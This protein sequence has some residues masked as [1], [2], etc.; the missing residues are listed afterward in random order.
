[1]TKHNN[2][3]IE[4]G[5]EELPPKHIRKLA[6][7][8][9]QGLQIE[10][11]RA[12]L[13]FSDIQSFATPRRLALI[14]K[15]LIAE[16]PEQTIKRKGPSLE[17]AFN[18]EGKPT[19]ACLGF[20]K[21]CSVSVEQLQK[22]Q[23][24]KGTWL[25]YRAK[26]AGA[27][28]HELL[29][30]L[31]KK[32]IKKLPIP[33][34]MRWS[35]LPTE[36][37]RPVHWLV[38]LYGKDVVH[39]DILGKTASNITYG[40][41]FHHPGP[42]KLKHADIYQKSLQKAFVV[43]CLTER[44][45][46]IK[47]Q[48]ESQA[49]EL[50][51]TPVIPDDLLDEVANIVEWP[52]ALLAKFD[53]AFLSI[54][55]E[56]LI[57]AMQDHQ[58]VFALEEHQ[59]KLLAQFIF[60]SNIASKKP[61][62]VIEGNEKVMRARLS[63]A[64]FFFEIDCKTPLSHRIEKLKSVVFQHKLGSVYDKTQRMSQLSK[65][66]ARHLSEDESASDKVATL[67]KADLVS[68]MVLEFP[69]LQGIM[70]YYYALNDQLPENIATAIRDHYLPRFSGDQLP[71]T[72]LSCIV[73]LADRIDTLTALFAID[74]PPTGD[75]DPF[76]LRRAAYGI[77]R[78]I[79]EKQLPLDLSELSKVALKTLEHKD[80]PTTILETLMDFYFERLRSWYLEKNISPDTLAAV[81]TQRPTCPFD[82]D[83]RVKAVTHFRTL[84]EASCLA[85]ANKRV[86]NIL[87]KEVNTLTDLT[88]NESLATEKAEQA[89]AKS[90][91]LYSKK[92]KP[93]KERA[94]YTE[95]LTTLAPLQTPIDR[96]FDEVMV[97][98]DDLKIRNNRL[99]L[100]QKLR[101]LFLQVADLSQL[102]L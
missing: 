29:P 67:A 38:L 14:V 81:I 71:S 44:R 50:N 42:I 85:A 20:A 8:F 59:N 87:R 92:I 23:T 74:Q 63:D 12:L 72:L 11:Q 54:P 56:V 45:T 10:L 26:Q 19:A 88:F 65:T 68:D 51:A 101:A 60:I 77:L 80:D 84:K 91:A 31:I 22:E 32:V 37:I 79:I 18:E 17:K 2:L 21:S 46:L 43:P 70:G 57:S 64:A 94:S 36:F 98:V 69:E 13:E 62:Q 102:Q 96:F 90:L 82:F 27:T 1:M 16:Q 97:M 93:L 73:A 15:D 52:T 76:G 40:H 75:K 61:Q 100:L 58:K 95:L 6:D 7:S 78:I 35:D 24:D 34:P 48:V 89:L 66:I 86:S 53:P 47:T 5:T 83:K 3:L 39:C 9:Q 30:L 55:P 33:K 25:V 99:A 28:I 49:H 4:I 41:R